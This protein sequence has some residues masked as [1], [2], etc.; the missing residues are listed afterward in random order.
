MKLLTSYLPAELEEIALSLGEK[1]FRGKQLF[2]WVQR[3]E[4]IS[5]MGNLPEAFRGRLEKD[6]VSDG[7]LI[8]QVAGSAEDGTEKYLFE[9]ADGNLIEGVSMRYSYGNTLCIS[10]QVGCRMCCAFCAS[11][12]G[13]LVR[14]LE[15]GE[16]MGQVI[17][18]NRHLGGTL[19]QRA[20]GNVVIM[21]SGEPLDNYEN[22]VKFL[23]LA[24][25]RE[26]LNIS[27]RNISLS[28][29]GIVPGI[30]DLAQE[31]LPITLCIS[32]HGPTDEIRR[33][34]MGIANAYK[35]DEIL[36]AVRY[37]IKQTGRRVIFEY[38][39]IDGIN[40][41]EDC[42]AGLARLLRGLQCHVNVI[43]LNPVAECGFAAS[44]EAVTA[45]FLSRLEHERISATRRRRMGA[46]VD[47]ACGQLRRRVLS[48]I[49]EG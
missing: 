5:S 16:M 4:P 42:A 33:K 47:G 8:R 6:Y 25:H 39:L 26:G 34:L 12:I 49:G 44:S 28:T 15:S 18:V 46:D 27:P 37:Y 31:S 29:C 32:L 2:Q 45:A 30:Y 48:E 24:A 38:A 1:R 17:A 9:L 40:D 11:T 3:G 19:K 23:H 14:N 20:V 13:G 22:V 43:P 36:D 21:G 7:V 10:S 41:S 35:I